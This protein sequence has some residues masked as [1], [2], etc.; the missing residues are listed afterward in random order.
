MVKR[1]AAGVKWLLFHVLRAL[2]MAVNL[3]PMSPSRFKTA[4]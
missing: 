4:F 2:G 3:N 1:K